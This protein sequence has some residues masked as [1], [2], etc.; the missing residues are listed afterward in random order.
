VDAVDDKP[1]LPFNAANPKSMVNK[2]NSCRA[3]VEDNFGFNPSAFQTRML[4]NT[5]TMSDCKILGWPPSE[6]ASFHCVVA[7]A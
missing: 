1:H 2:T 7:V 4:K 5:I 3:I 6:H